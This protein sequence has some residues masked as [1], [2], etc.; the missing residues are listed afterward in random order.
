MGQGQQKNMWCHLNLDII[1]LSEIS[2]CYS[3]RES[4]NTNRKNG[5]TIELGIKWLNKENLEGFYSIVSDMYL[6][7]RP[8]KLLWKV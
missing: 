6:F 7:A 3:I 8:S 1:S 5:K 4:F 2:C